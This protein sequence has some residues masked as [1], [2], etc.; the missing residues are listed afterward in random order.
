MTKFDR[1]LSIITLITMI[2]LIVTV[3]RIA[4]GVPSFV[5]KV[6]TQ[7]QPKTCDIMVQGACIPM[8]V[9]TNV[10]VSEVAG[11]EKIYQIQISYLT[12]DIPQQQKPEV[13]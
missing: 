12:D 3:I 13:K 4:Q 7:A 10:Q 2:A 6:Q 1:A 8:R 5:S 11:F 9:D